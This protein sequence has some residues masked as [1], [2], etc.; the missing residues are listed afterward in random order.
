[1]LNLS[2]YSKP[3]KNSDES[4]F[5]FVKEMLDGDPTY[6]INF[7]RIQWDSEEENWVIIEYLRC[8]DKQ[9]SRGI[10]PHTSHPNRY[11]NKN[12]RKFIS[13]WILKC[14]LNAKLYLVNYAKKSENLI[15]DQIKLIEVLNI[16]IDGPNYVITVDQEMKREEFSK[17]LRDM[18]QRGKRL[19]G[20][21]EQYTK[22]FKSAIP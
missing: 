10:T 18:N 7:D 1:M 4:G 5:E 15:T 3:L 12:A 9:F 22:L 14:A 8:H 16:K 2:D 11:F 17:W 20:L 6:G 13:L 19:P 21:I